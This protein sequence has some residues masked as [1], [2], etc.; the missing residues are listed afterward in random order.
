MLPQKAAT[1]QVSADVLRQLEELL[2]TEQDPAHVYNEVMDLLAELE[3]SPMVTD[4]DPYID[5]CIRGAYQ[6]AKR[7]AE[8]P[9]LF[10]VALADMSLASSDAAKTFAIA[11]AREGVRTG[12]VSS[13][14]PD[15][16]ASYQS[17]DNHKLHR[18]IVRNLHTWGQDASLIDLAFEEAYF[19]RLPEATPDVWEGEINGQEV[20]VLKANVLSPNYPGLS[21]ALKGCAEYMSKWPE[22]R[23][24]KTRLEA[25]LLDIGRDPRLDPREMEEILT[26]GEG[27]LP[28]FIKK[29]RA[30]R[31]TY[32]NNDTQ[33]RLQRN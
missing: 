9:E 27:L 33:A 7:F 10:A 3:R 16:W 23:I 21:L 1:A 6:L 11:L 24:A 4:K 12:H 5:L 30:L 32:T 28:G 18:D 25:H 26:Q 31:P 20:R 19:S 17:T 14:A 29:L 2:A 13:A 8:A 15:L 22:D